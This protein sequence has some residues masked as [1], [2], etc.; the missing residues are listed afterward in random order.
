MELKNSH[1]PLLRTAFILLSLSVI[2]TTNSALSCKKEKEEKRPATNVTEHDIMSSNGKRWMV[3]IVTLTTYNTSGGT[4]SEEDLDIEDNIGVWFG[5]NGGVN[6]L[7]K[8]F[9]ASELLLDYFPFA[10]SWALNTATQKITITCSP[11]Y[12]TSNKSSEW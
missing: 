11:G 10:A 1:T 5:D 2:F 8:I 6:G 12:C 3:R 4:E 7:N 9:S